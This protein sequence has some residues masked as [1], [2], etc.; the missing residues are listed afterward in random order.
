MEMMVS[1]DMCALIRERHSP[2][3]KLRVCVAQGGLPC[4]VLAPV[5][6]QTTWRLPA[7][8]LVQGWVG[9]RTS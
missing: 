7:I 8:L 5:K 3:I 9:W 4:V 1:W 6:L 2:S